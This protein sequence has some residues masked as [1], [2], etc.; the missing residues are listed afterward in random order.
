MVTGRGEYEGCTPP[1]V[2]TAAAFDISHSL[3]NNLTDV[4]QRE[5]VCVC[6]WVG[7]I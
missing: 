1:A 7:I 3:P 6:V 5:C 4:P 2:C